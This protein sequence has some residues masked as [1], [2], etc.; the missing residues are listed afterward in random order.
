M[1]ARIGLSCRFNT[2][3]YA[4]AYMPATGQ[5]YF[6]NTKEIGNYPVLDF[7]VSAK[8][9]TARLFFKIEHLNDGLLAQRDAYELPHYPLPGRAFQFG[10][11]WRFF[12]F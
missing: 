8:I 7:F 3:Y 10:I 12:D 4:D 6:Q 2:L 11:S 5:F 9:K 1:Q